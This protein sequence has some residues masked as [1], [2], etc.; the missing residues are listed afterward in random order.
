MVSEM[1][2]A[3]NEDVR[4]NVIV[5]SLSNSEPVNLLNVIVERQSAEAYWALVEV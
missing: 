1:Q 5:H 3:N 4:E 2:R